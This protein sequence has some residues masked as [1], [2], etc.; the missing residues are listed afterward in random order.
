MI[1]LMETGQEKIDIQQ[2]IHTYFPQVDVQEIWPG[3]PL[4]YKVLHLA[5]AERILLNME[6][7][8]YFYIEN[9]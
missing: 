6:N 3:N 5:R 4:L 1:F 2:H 8:Q 7:A 9:T